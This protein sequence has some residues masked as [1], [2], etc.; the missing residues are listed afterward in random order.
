MI[1][2]WELKFFRM[3]AHTIVVSQTV[4][5][6]FVFNLRAI[7]N[8]CLSSDHDKSRGSIEKITTTAGSESIEKIIVY[9]KSLLHFSH[10]ENTHDGRSSSLFSP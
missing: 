5:T 4:Y 10:L 7:I 2:R 6:G 3:R 8:W 1:N 9:D